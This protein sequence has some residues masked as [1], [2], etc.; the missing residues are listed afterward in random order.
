MTDQEKCLIEIK[1]FGN[2]YFIFNK[3]D[4]KT[5]R[6]D[7][8]IVGALNGTLPAF[9]LQN[10]F[11]GL[12]LILLPEEVDLLL[13]KGWA[14]LIT[15]TPRL[16][17]P[18][19]DRSLIFG[20]FWSLGF[21]L[22]NGLKFGGDFV[23][24]RDDPMCVHSDYIVSVREPNEPIEPIDLVAAGRVATTV[25]KTFVLTSIVDEQVISYSIEWAGF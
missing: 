13:S 20:H 9:P 14:R 25:K 23:L 18:S 17:S 24:Y 10:T 8:R 4:V 22:T 3:D 1:Q 7:Y 21:Y 11:F 16:S 12:P 15:K 6:C 2:K 19:T 5:L